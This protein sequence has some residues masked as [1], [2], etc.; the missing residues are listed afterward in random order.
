MCFILSI[1][2]KQFLH[3]NFK[4]IDKEIEKDGFYND[5]HIKKDNVNDNFRHIDFSEQKYP[6]L[7]D[8]Y[9]TEGE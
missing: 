2:Y 1:K 8:D 3:Y 9:E 5:T 7:G 4:K 6:G